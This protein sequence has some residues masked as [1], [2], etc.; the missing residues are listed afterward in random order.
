MPITV[1]CINELIQA[2][3]DKNDISDGYHTFRELYDHRVELWIAFCSMFESYRTVLSM[4]PVTWRSKLHSDGSSYPGWFVLG[5]GTLPGEQITYHLPED[6]W[7]SC[8]FAQIRETA[9][10]FDGHTPKDVLARLKAL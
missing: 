3:P 9:P 1:E 7:S 6:K 8:D 5:V 2:L 10:E 4:S